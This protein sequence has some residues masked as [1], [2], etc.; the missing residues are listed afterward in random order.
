MWI[1]KIKSDEFQTER[2]NL[3]FSLSLSRDRDYGYGPSLD[4]L[5]EPE[6]QRSKS[7]E[8]I[9]RDGKS[10]WRVPTG[11]VTKFPSELR[12]VRTARPSAA[13]LTCR[14]IPFRLSCFLFSRPTSFLSP[15]L[16]R[17]RLR[18]CNW[19]ARYAERIHR[20]S[21]PRTSMFVIYICT[22]CPVKWWSI[23][24]ELVILRGEDKRRYRG[25]NFARESKFSEVL[26]NEF[27]GRN[28]NL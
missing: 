18:R 25:L 4:R 15:F 8:T 19:P 1:D 22:W 23:H 14:P 6:V 28:A 12:L 13:S 16:V 10:V 20:V 26:G 21:Q 24:G 9:G 2:P 7:P 11:S 5:I 17:N 27:W 3:S